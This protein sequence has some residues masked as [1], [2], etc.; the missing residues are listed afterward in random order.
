MRPW[1]EAKR[2]G[3]LV[4]R[5]TTPSP[6]KEAFDLSFH[7]F[8]EHRAHMKRILAPFALTPMQMHALRALAPGVPQTMANL[9]EMIFC[10]PPNVTPVVDKL[11]SLGLVERASDPHDRRI[12]HVSLTR[13]GEA[14]RRDILRAL[15]ELPRAIASLPLADQHALRNLLRKMIDA[16]EQPAKEW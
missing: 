4:T 11:E 6:G 9:S 14:M 16:I 7:Y 12:K 10:D 13:D 1:Q 15:E 5:K 3:P 8:R 2:G